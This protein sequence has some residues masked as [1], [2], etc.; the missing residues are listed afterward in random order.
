MADSKFTT[1]ADALRSDCFKEAVCVNA[2]RVYDACRDRECLEDM[3][4]YFVERD[5]EIIDNALSVRLKK[6]EVINVFIDTEPVQF[7]R[8]Y[9][10]VDLTI[11]FCVTLDV[12]LSPISPVCEVS[13]LCIYNKKAVLYGSEGSVKVF[14]SDYVYD[15][16]DMQNPPMGNL[17]KATVSIAEPVSLGAKLVK[18]CEPCTPCC[19]PKCVCRRFAGNF[20]CGQTEKQCLVSLGIF[21]IIQLERQVQMLIPVYDFCMPE[22]VCVESGNDDPCDLF[23]SI[24]FPTSEFFPP[25]AGDLCD[26]RVRKCGCSERKA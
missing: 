15:D 4:V 13:G 16:D 25:R 1:A 5:Q 2:S 26:S 21:L 6:S 24:Q 17:P 11:Y 10:C 23:R 19:I 9:Y 7:N 22:K 3:Q 18:T 8:G 20:S 12:T 14:S